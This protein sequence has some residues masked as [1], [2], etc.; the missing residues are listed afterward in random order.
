M[1]IEE[2]LRSDRLRPVW[3]NLH[4]HKQVVQRKCLLK[5]YGVPMT[6]GSSHSQIVDL[7]TIP[8][9]ELSGTDH[10]GSAPYGGETSPSV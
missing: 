8:Y 10:P 6:R 3:R 9:G 5:A 4:K 1:R 2:R 7:G